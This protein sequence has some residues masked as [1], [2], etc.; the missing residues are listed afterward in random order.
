LLRSTEL[1]VKAV[2][3]GSVPSVRQASHLFNVN[4][5][6][7]HNRLKGKRTVKELQQARQRLSTQ[8][9]ESIKHCIYTMTAWGWPTTIRYVKSLATGLLKAKG[10]LEPLGQN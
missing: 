2:R 6:T 5:N 7:I 8:E 9:E 10:D 4:R 1:A 3:E